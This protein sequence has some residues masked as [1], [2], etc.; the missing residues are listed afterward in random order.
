MSGAGALDGLRVVEMGSFIAGPF[1]GQLLA[2]QGAHVVKIEP[3]GTG[4]SMRQWGV[5]QREGK[6]LWW[7]VIARNKRSLTLDLRQPEG[8]EIARALL[9]EADVLIENFRPG[10]IERWG[11]APDVLQAANPRLIIA[12][13]SGFGQ[14]GPY[15]TRVGFGAIAEAMA[16]M[17]SLGGFPDQPPPRA[18]LSIGDSLAGMFT[19]IGVLSALNARHASGRGQVIDVGITDAVLGVMESVFAEHSATGAVRRRTG[20]GL[21]GIAPSNLY[22]TADGQWVLVAGN[23]DAIFRRLAELM[24]QPALATDPRYATHRARGERQAELDAL[25]AAWTA[26][27]PLTALLEGLDAAGV[28]AGPVAGIDDAAANPHFQARGALVEVETEDYGALTMQAVVPRLS[29]TPGA[30]RWVGPRLGEHTEEVL[31][32]ALGLDAEAVEGLRARGIV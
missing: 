27:L 26:T 3:P 8:T 16:G 13:V 21:P 10:T 1:C 19:T 6:A 15:S 24:G 28:P 22:P 9:A 31:R 25:V 5:V 7:P 20:T 29:E 12:R 30:V 11:M 23:G 4:D 18:G 14:T 2:D 17:R 32:E